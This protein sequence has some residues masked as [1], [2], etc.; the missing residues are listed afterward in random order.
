MSRHLPNRVVN[1][2]HK[3]NKGFNS[4][5]PYI[6]YL[7]ILRIVSSVL[8]TLFKS[9]HKTMRTR[10]GETEPAVIM[11]LAIK[12][13]KNTLDSGCSQIWTKKIRWEIFKFGLNKHKIRLKHTNSSFK[14]CVVLWIT[15]KIFIKMCSNCLTKV[16]ELE[17]IRWNY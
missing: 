5:E 8:F 10:W 16:K 6:I 12:I 3:D 15:L 2:I 4:S 17:K 1:C 13:L 11:C 7:K 14:D 9:N